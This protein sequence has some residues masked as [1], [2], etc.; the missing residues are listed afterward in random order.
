MNHQ[1][2][3]TNGG[4]HGSSHIGSRGWSYRTSMG[5]EALGPMK[6]QCPSVEECQDSEVGVGRLVSRGWDRGFSEGSKERE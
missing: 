1:P 5:G 2:K 3:R 6:A 4:T